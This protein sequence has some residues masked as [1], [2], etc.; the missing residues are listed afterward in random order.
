MVRDAASELSR[1][2]LLRLLASPWEREDL[3]LKETIDLTGSHGWVALAKDVLAMANT[4]GGHIIIGVE[5]KT[6]R[7][8]GLTKKVSEALQEPKKINDQLKNYCGGYIRIL[9]AQHDLQEP[10]V[11]QVRLALVYVP[12]AW[13]PVPAQDNGVYPDPGDPKKQKWIFRK[14]DIYVRKGDESVKIETPEDLELGRPG[15]EPAQ[16]GPGI[17][18]HFTVG[19]LPWPFIASEPFVDREDAFRKLQSAVSPGAIVPVTGL[20]DSGKSQLVAHFLSD[21]ASVE[22]V[23]KK[24]AHPLSVLYV[25]L[26]SRLGVLRSLGFALGHSKL[27]SLNDV[28]VTELTSEEYA[29]AILIGQ[30][31]PG[32]LRQTAPLAVFENSHIALVQPKARRELDEILGN[33]VFN[34]GSALVITRHGEIPTGLERRKVKGEIVVEKLSEADA[35][36]L[37]RQLV[38]DSELSSAAVNETSGLEELLLPGVLVRGANEFLRRAEQGDIHRTTNSLIDTLIGTTRYI[39]RE[40]LTTLGID[41]ITLA[42]GSL[43]PLATLLVMAIVGDHRVF[44]KQLQASGLPQPPLLSLSRAGLIEDDGNSYRLTALAR[45]GL[46]RQVEVL[47]GEQPTSAEAA[48][49]AHVLRSYVDALAKDDNQDLSDCYTAAFEEALSWLQQKLPHEKEIR[50]ILLQVFLPNTTDDAVF[51]LSKA[52]CARLE[53]E[54]ATSSLQIGAAV[55]TLTMLARSEPHSKPQSHR[56]QPRCGLD[57]TDAESGIELE[58][59]KYE[60]NIQQSLENR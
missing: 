7:K 60:R 9:V 22:A 17:V 18:R 8:I 13:P 28:S 11:E 45:H 12:P 52:E 21:P 10:A 19:K 49:L 36:S 23:G 41:N 20:P 39:T 35:N 46:R 48:T 34:A 54:M 26:G 4:G 5:D 56:T 47:F 29:K 50:D 40:I 32:R 53:D 42:N 27:A 2:C 58:S 33:D 38:G 55:A 59:G 16:G 15:F 6:L 44:H 3:D 31:L 1:D 25:D 24:F 37:L 51:P 43:G 30:I 57:T 14:G